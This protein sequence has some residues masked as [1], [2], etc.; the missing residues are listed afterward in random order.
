MT[1]YQSLGERGMAVP[2]A[3]FMLAAGFAFAKT[4]RD[5]AFLAGGGL[6][7]L[8]AMYVAVAFVSVPF[9]MSTLALMRR[10]GGRRAHAWMSAATAG[11]L[12]GI[13]VRPPLDSGLL[14]T[15]AYIVVPLVFGVLF[16]M[17]WLAVPTSMATPDGRMH[18]RAFLLA[19]AA[20]LAGGASAGL[21]TAS[22]G[23]LASSAVL[24][25]AAGGLV[26]LGALLMALARRAAASRSTT[27]HDTA[28][29]PAPALPLLV[30]AAALAAIVGVF[31]E[32]QFYIAVAETPAA[33]DATARLAALHVGV[34]GIALAGLLLT[35]WLQRL[36]GVGGALALL[37]AAVGAGAAGVWLGGAALSRVFLRAAEGGLK[38]SIHRVSW[39]QVLLLL[40]LA[41][42]PRVKMLLDGMT[43][44]IAEGGAG[45]LLWGLVGADVA[46]QAITGALVLLSGIWLTIAARLWH[47]TARLSPRATADLGRIPD[48]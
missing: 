25:L 6:P 23:A 47:A 28:P 15:L 5:A 2:A 48:S 33:A 19:G 32:Y 27:Q 42:R 37:P 21:I 4:G 36:A 1:A 44:R 43:T 46:P 22:A 7:V 13:S 11:C 14:S 17:S 38:A 12:L 40:P 26:A 34:N 24:F 16:S 10:V 8:P 3:L 39:E 18:P 9:G 31:V 41:S 20:T 35:P 30:A 29:P 45:L